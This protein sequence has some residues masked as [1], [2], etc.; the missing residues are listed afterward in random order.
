MPALL[1][2]DVVV[3]ARDVSGQLLFPLRG[4]SGLDAAVIG[5]RTRLLLFQGEWFLNLSAGVPWLPTAD[6]AVPESAAILGQAFDEI[7]VRAA[8]LAEILT[9]PG[10]IDVPVLRVAYDGPT[11]A[12][13]IAWQA[14]CAFGDTPVDVVTRTI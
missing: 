8:I 6:G 2:T 3:F 9:C 11:R 12:L 5:V 10:V 1:S 4:V 7:K 14:R 13:T